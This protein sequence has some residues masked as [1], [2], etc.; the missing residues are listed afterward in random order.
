MIAMARLRIVAMTWGPLPVRTWGVVFAVGD[1]ADMVQG[2]DLPVTTDPGG[3]LGRGCLLGVQA[4][5]GVDGDSP[6]PSA[7]QGPDSAAEADGLGGVREGQP[8]GDGDG[9]E[10]PVLVPAVGAVVLAGPG[11]DLP[12][13][14]PLELGVQAGLVLFHDEE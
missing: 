7:V 8:G 5:D 13:G 11:R 6:P 14:Q 2:F 12:P 10:G 3:E 1:V 4:G 9:F